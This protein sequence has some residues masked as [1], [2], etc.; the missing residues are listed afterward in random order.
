MS[1][2]AVSQSAPVQLSRGSE[3]AKW[4]LHIH[5]PLSGLNNQ[6][7][8]L[9]N[10]QPDWDAYVEKLETLTDIHVIGIT[11][12]FSIEG[13]RKILEFRNQG[14]LK[15]FS[16]ILPNIEFRLDRIIT[17]SQGPRRL[18]YHVIFSDKLTPEEIEEHFLHELKF[19]YE[20]DPQRAD[21]NLSVRRSN[22]ELLGNRLKTKHKKFDDNRSDFEIGCMTATVDPGKIKEVL[23]NK[24]QVFG[25]KY[26]IVLAEEYLSLLNWD[27]QDHLTRKILLQGADGIISANPQTG[28]WARGEGDLSVEQFRSEFKS[29]K[30]CLHGCDTHCLDVIG[31]PAE[32]RYCWIK[33]EHTFEGLKQVLYEPGERLFIGD[34][35]V[36]LKNDYQVIENV[37]ISNTPDWFWRPDSAAK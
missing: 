35:P 17:T 18:N 14:R 22:L 34:K 15:H 10:G 33:A 11:D 28:R 26:L 19:S 7:P 2:A 8:R 31:K 30:P 5:S 20:G 23:Q 29:L 1:T 37:S 24:E 21:L 25:G 4:D 3:W 13:Y 36:Y 6:F 12:Y 32:S 9:A 27:G 16:L